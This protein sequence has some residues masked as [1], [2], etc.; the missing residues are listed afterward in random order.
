M[1]LV[2]SIRLGNSFRKGV[3]KAVSRKAGVGEYEIS[4]DDP[5]ITGDRRPE[6]DT[7]NVIFN[8]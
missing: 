6:I 4:E 1:A 8:F 7:F 3:E 2:A 5:K